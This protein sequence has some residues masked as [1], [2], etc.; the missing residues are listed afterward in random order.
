[1]TESEDSQNMT[2]ESTQGESSYC[3]LCWSQYSGPH[4]CPAVANSAKGRIRYT[5]I[6]RSGQ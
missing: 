4:H 1:M 3:G 2:S 5:S 6:S